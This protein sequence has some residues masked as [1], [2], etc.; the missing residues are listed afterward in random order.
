MEENKLGTLTEALAKAQAAFPEI[1]RNRTV[2]VQTQRGN[3]SFKYATLDVILK[4]IRKPLAENGLAI[5]QQVVVQDGKPYLVTRLLHVS[6]GMLESI[7][8]ILCKDMNN[9]AFGSALH[10]MRRYTLTAILGIAAQEDDDA[11]VA[12]GNVMQV[13]DEE[14]PDNPPSEEKPAPRTS[15]KRASQK[16][17]KFLRGLVDQAGWDEGRLKSE[18]IG[19]YNVENLEDLSKQDAGSLIERLL[20]LVKKQ[21]E[22]APSPEEE[23]PF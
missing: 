12:E 19:A 10:Y 13:L 23:V 17:V 2:V 18:L 16:Q 7:S 3:Y 14:I 15:P 21:E 9:Q 6:G 20:A 8:P 1:E 11:N 5:T 22:K 4:A